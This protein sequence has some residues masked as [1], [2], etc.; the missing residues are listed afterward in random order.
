MINDN[1]D[2]AIICVPTP[3]L[4]LNEQA[5]PDNAMIFY[6]VDTSIV[7][8]SV[9]W[10]ETPLVLIKST[11]PPETTN[12]LKMKYGKRICFSPEYMGEGGYYIP[13]Q[14]PDPTD[15]RQHPWMI[16]G[17]DKEDCDAIVD[18]FMPQLGPSKTY[19]TCTAVEAELIKY[20]ENTW[21]ATKV[22]FANEWRNICDAFE[23]S[24]NTVREGWALDS[25]V[26]RMHTAVFPDKRGFGGK[27]LPKDL[28]GI[29][30]ACI[31]NDY[32]PELLKKVWRENQ[33]MR[34]V[35]LRWEHKTYGLLKD[36]TIGVPTKNNPMIEFQDIAMS[37]IKLCKEE[38]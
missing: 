9:E 19:Y 13:P 21:I 18:I 32:R 7:E 28:H 11:I 23:A 36:G 16:V 24:Y 4:G 14:H 15:P 17:G 30:S 34:G 35:E 8:E 31:K 22:T 1:C 3:P 38:A 27:C 6:D 20:M 33:R 29:I 26:E 2:L 37:R 12:K 5:V 10:L 25:R